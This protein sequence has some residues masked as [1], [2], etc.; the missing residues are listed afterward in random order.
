MSSDLQG[1]KNKVMD[2]T[3]G[4]GRGWGGVTD[5]GRHS[6]EIS[7]P[8]VTLQTE[9]IEHKVTYGRCKQE[10]AGSSIF[11]NFCQGDACCET[12]SILQFGTFDEKACAKKSGRH[13]FSSAHGQ[14]AIV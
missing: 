10:K 11:P 14:W 1:Q 3:P 8:S 13:I 5:P 6:S 2:R 9:L 12:F 4:Q 7:V